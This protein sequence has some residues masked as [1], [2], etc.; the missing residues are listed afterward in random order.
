MLVV[1]AFLM[2]APAVAG[3]LCVGVVFGLIE[4]FKMASVAAFRTDLMAI[5]TPHAPTVA[6][7]ECQLFDDNLFVP[8]GSCLAMGT[9]ADMAAI[10]SALRM[11][12]MHPTSP[13]QAQA[14]PRGCLSRAGLRT[15]PAVQIFVTTGRL[16]VLFN[17][18]IAFFDPVRGVLCFEGRYAWG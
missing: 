9:A 5:V 6:P 13:M 10:R 8:A 14:D 3:A 11:E 15:A 18:L 12:R 2:L 4:A 17:H 7:S 16:G 1:I